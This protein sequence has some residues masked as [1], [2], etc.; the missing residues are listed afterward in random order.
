MKLKRLSLILLVFFVFSLGC[1][2]KKEAVVFDTPY[3]EINQGSTITDVMA[4]LGNPDDINVLPEEK[5]ELWY[6]YFGE[7]KKVYVY[8]VNKKVV[9]VRDTIEEEEK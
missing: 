4:T 9:K 8:F 3:G 6:Y 1:A 5:A 2:S 7:D